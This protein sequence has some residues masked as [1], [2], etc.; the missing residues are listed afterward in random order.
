M[1]TV[2]RGEKIAWTSV[3]VLMV[4]KLL[5]IFK[6]VSYRYMLRVSRLSVL[7]GKE[8]HGELDGEGLLTV[9]SNVTTFFHVDR[10]Q[11]L[12]HSGGAFEIVR[13]E[14][15]KQLYLAEVHCEGEESLSV[16]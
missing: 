3:D 12:N 7:R 14:Q 10:I 4:S 9:G 16:L 15:C 8:G 11:T 6:T 1:T 5:L 13:Y 2:D